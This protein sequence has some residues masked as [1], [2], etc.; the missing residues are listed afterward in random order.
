MLGPIVGHSETNKTIEIDLAFETRRPSEMD[1][2]SN[3]INGPGELNK[4]DDLPIET[5]GPGEIDSSSKTLERPLT[6]NVTDNRLENCID[7]K[8]SCLQNDLIDS[9]ISTVHFN[10]SQLGNDVEMISEDVV[11]VELNC[12]EIISTDVVQADPDCHKMIS[13]NTVHTESDS[14][15]AVQAETDGDEM[16]SKDAVHDESDD[17]M[18]SKDAVRVETDGDEM[19]SKDAVHDKSDDETISKDAVRAKSDD[20]KIS[21][22]AVQA[23][24]DVE[25]ISKDA[26]QAESDVEMISKDAVQAESDDETISK[27]AV[28]AESDGDEIISKDAVRAKSNDGVMISKDVVP[29]KPDVV[30]SEFLSTSEHLEEMPEAMMSCSAEEINTGEEKDVN[31]EF[32]ATADETNI[33]SNEMKSDD[34]VA[35]TSSEN[36]EKIGGILTLTEES[37]VLEKNSSGQSGENDDRVAVGALDKPN[38]STTEMSSDGA[39]ATSDE[40]VDMSEST[41]DPIRLDDFAPSCTNVS[42][43]EQENHSFIEPKT[44]SLTKRISKNTDVITIDD[45]SSS[46]E[47]ESTSSLSDDEDYESYEDSIDSVVISDLEDDE[48]SE[49]NRLGIFRQP[50][51]GVPKNVCQKLIADGAELSK[52]VASVSESNKSDAKLSVEEVA[53]RSNSILGNEESKRTSCLEASEVGIGLNSSEQME[54]SN[55]CKNVANDIQKNTVCSSGEHSNEAND[56][57]GSKLK[58][59]DGKETKNKTNELQINL[60]LP[61]GDPPVICLDMDE[62][63]LILNKELSPDKEANKSVE[64]CIEINDNDSPEK[65][66]IRSSLPRLPNRGNAPIVIDVKVAESDR[67]NVPLNI[68]ENEHRPMSKMLY[69]LGLQLASEQVLTN[70]IHLQK[71][72]MNKS[73][74]DVTSNLLE[75]LEN[76]KK[77]LGPKNEYLTFSTKSC[78]CG[79]K[80]SSSIVLKH[81]LRFGADMNQGKCCICDLAMRTEKCFVKHMQSQHKIF[82]SV[83]TKPARHQCCF[84]TYETNSRAQVLSHVKYCQ[85]LFLPRNHLKPQPGDCDIPFFWPKNRSSVKSPVKSPNQNSSIRPT[86]ALL[87]VKDTP[88]QKL[89]QVD[90]RTFALLKRFGANKPNEHVLMPVPLSLPNKIVS[91]N[92]DQNA[93]PIVTSKLLASRPFQIQSQPRPTLVPNKSPV[94]VNFS[95]MKIDVRPPQPSLFR[96]DGNKAAVVTKP[97]M[98]SKD[99]HVCPICQG[100]IKDY[101]SL[102]VHIKIVHKIIVDATKLYMCN[103][104]QPSTRFHSKLELRAHEESVHH[105]NIQTSVMYLKPRTCSI[106]KDDTII[107]FPGHLRTV[108]GVK[109]SLMMQSY[110]C[111]FCS[112]QFDMKLEFENH[113]LIVHSDL[114]DSVNMLRE[115]AE[116]KN[117]CHLCENSQPVSLVEHFII[118]HKVSLADMLVNRHCSLCPRKFP[119]ISSFEAH[120]Q[121]NH[122]EYFPN[123]N[124]LWTAVFLVAK[125]S[126]VAP[127]PGPSDDGICGTYKCFH[128]RDVFVSKSYRYRHFLL[129]HWRIIRICDICTKRVIAGPDFIRHVKRKHLRPCSVVLKRSNGT[130]LEAEQPLSNRRQ[131]FSSK[132]RRLSVED[133]VVIIDDEDSLDEQEP[134]SVCSSRSSRRV[135]FIECS[136][137]SR[138]G[139]GTSDVPSDDASESDVLIES[140]IDLHTDIVDGPDVI[141]PNIV[142]KPDGVVE[143]DDVVETD[144]VIEPDGVVETDDIVEP[145]VVIETDDVVEPDSVIEPDDAVEPDGVVET[146]DIVEP[147]SVVEPDN[148]VEPDDVIEPRDT[149]ESNTVVEPDDVMETDDVIESEADVEPDGDIAESD[150]LVEPTIDRS[151]PGKDFFECNNKNVEEILY[152]DGET[153]VIVQEEDENEEV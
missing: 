11:Q 119:S 81:H 79:F 72:S 43:S 150:R 98:I 103:L 153:V 101:D 87:A 58:Q 54:C 139:V 23:E 78:R 59:V 75:K 114:F 66:G 80:A 67:Q 76:S 142:I 19:I 18:I 13:E 97:A 38:T 3:N 138:N 55:V 5:I 90:G 133:T 27:D 148:V 40:R 8:S 47:T 17:E 71:Q 4:S 112:V 51:N 56:S 115:T 129:K 24:S 44:N 131:R 35:K 122:S 134:Q 96:V 15:D 94:N 1:K 20:E 100:I 95:S 85:E 7:D 144:D 31:S 2:S 50:F 107:D 132:I 60:K 127:D 83:L 102:M 120:M 140:D 137:V 118:V 53:T 46:D 10:N 136:T 16:I 26:V 82:T 65:S 109:L 146:D 30:S 73:P 37:K 104:C 123:L 77:A 124:A 61:S 64:D 151:M 111:H 41:V 70:L 116:A 29:T 48:I 93:T 14:K 91:S 74:N 88:T 89:I 84:C 108:H 68:Q 45:S 92:S 106:C 34:D 110:C 145:D 57:S 121:R 125:S 152:I 113:M 69:D 33:T 12:D 128:C 52:T 141:R 42:K 22:D 149:I 36:G 39:E 135:N 62:D 21:K 130:S 6:I 117:V 86:N 99:Y 63:D 143:P 9:P 49:L 28:Q 25:M 32:D 126:N 147:D 105:R